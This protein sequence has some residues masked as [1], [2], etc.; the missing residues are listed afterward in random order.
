[1]EEKT[2]DYDKAPFR[3][4]VKSPNESLELI[5]ALYGR[6]LYAYIRTFFYDDTHFVQDVISE[7]FTV[8]WNKRKKV[9]KLKEPFFWMLRV[10]KNR[11][12][13]ILREEGKHPLQAI[14][15]LDSLESAEFIDPASEQDGKELM[16][17]ICEI[18]RT[19]LTS[20]EQEIFY[21]FKFEGLSY[22]ELMER[23]GLAKQTVKNKV[24]VAV[25]KVRRALKSIL[26][27]LV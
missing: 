7:T 13:N 11:A 15:N 16:E 24:T 1:M 5:Y 25:R 22:E 20:S 14:D 17:Q 9:A 6:Q 18:C 27:V 4:L 8:M 21:G 26:Q 19:Q 23:H 10:A 3:A 2:E 12:L